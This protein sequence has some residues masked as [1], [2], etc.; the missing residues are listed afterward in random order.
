[1]IV[2]IIDK[3]TAFNQQDKTLFKYLHVFLKKQA[4]KSISQNEMYEEVTGLLK[5]LGY[6]LPP[7]SIRSQASLAKYIETLSQRAITSWEL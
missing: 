3:L 6:S 4:G 2:E 5:V 7:K 1:L